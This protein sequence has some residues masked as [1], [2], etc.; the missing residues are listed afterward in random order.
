MVAT[1]WDNTQSSSLMTGVV[2]PQITLI[3]NHPS[4]MGIQILALEG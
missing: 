4:Y 2:E 3:I 1:G